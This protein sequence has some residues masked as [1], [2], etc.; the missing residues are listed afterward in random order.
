[1]VALTDLSLASESTPDLGTPD[2][3]LLCLQFLARYFER[4]SSETVLTAGLP[5]AQG[6]LTPELAPTAA[7]RIGLATK[8]SKHPLAELVPF[9]LPCIILTTANRAVVLLEGSAQTCR[10]Y[11][12]DF[13]S[14]MS[15]PRAEVEQ[16]YSGLAITI[17]PRFGRAA[18]D[19]GVP[20]ALHRG[21]WFFSSLALHWRSFLSIGMAAAIINI[22]GIT[23]PL[24]TMNVYDRV[25][26][27]SAMATLWVL[28]IGFAV[29]LVFDL[30]LKTARA[31]LLDTVGKVLDI[32]LSSAIFEKI[33]NTPLV[34]RSNST[35]EFVNRVTQYE[36]VREFFTSSTIVLFVDAAFVF[37]YLLVIY[38]VAG[39]LVAIPIMA[40]IIVIAI[41]LLLQYLIGDEIGKSQTE[42][43]LRHA[44]LVEAVGAIETIKTM[45]AEG[46]F[47]RRWD[48]LIRVA[49]A[50]QERI[51]SISSLGINTTLFFQQLVTIGIIV[52][53]AYRFANREITT[54]AII[55]AVMLSSRALAP[56]SQ[57]AMTLTR[58]RYAISA[59]KTLNAVMNLEDERVSTESFVN[60][61]VDQGRLEFKDVGFQYPLNSR[62]VLDRINLAIVPGEKVGIIGKVGSGKT[63]FGR[64]VAGFYAPTRGEILIDGV[65]LR[66]YHPH[67]IRKAVGLVMQDTDLFIG[68]IKANL[69]LANPSASDAD[70]VRAAKLAGVD[71]F[72][73]L[74]PLGYDLPVGERGRNLSTGQKQAVALARV[75]LAD[76]KILFLDEPSSAMDLAT[77]Q[78]FLKRLRSVMRPDQTLLITTH[79]FSM[80]ELVDRLVILENGRIVADGKKDDV[81]AALKR[82][83]Q[84]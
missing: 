78:N 15:A 77:E 16:Y 51:K 38:A 58:V 60:R 4:P 70:I 74:H 47:L 65:D 36:F 39:W 10:V 52:A 6:K 40:M 11:A 25:L 45:R 23:T 24:F 57:I 82:Q 50:T 3:L 63:T 9:K 29:V 53:G 20:T 17:E 31:L 73:S 67:E 7:A 22:V 5:L 68:S 66:Q 34:A 80:L 1:V 12:P 19:P 33:M 30:V 21:H 75:L 54:G 43:S 8:M 62:F 26:P 81:L 32:A 56:M 84:V 72:V 83:A 64:L 71:D 42:S 59:M 13:D 76:P 2:D 61:A 46:Q 37:V 49:S 79:R 28:A 41:G 35:G 48:R 14:I 69:L 27:N 18:V 44:M 55:A